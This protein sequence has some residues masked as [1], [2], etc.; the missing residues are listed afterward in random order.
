MN[1]VSNHDFYFMQQKDACGRM[2]LSTI[3][4]CIVALRMLAYGVAIDVINEY[5]HLVETTAIECLKHFVKGFMQ[6]LNVSTCNSHC[7]P[8]WKKTQNQW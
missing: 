2:G 4:K 3:Q 8:T 6:F 1:V 7:R 5:Y